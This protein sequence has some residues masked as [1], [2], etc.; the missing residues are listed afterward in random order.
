MSLYLL[1]VKAFV[2][3][4]PNVFVCVSFVWWEGVGW[5]LIQQSNINYPFKMRFNY[6]DVY[7]PFIY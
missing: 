1:E 5:D 2:I 3:Q 7:C 6:F 4:L